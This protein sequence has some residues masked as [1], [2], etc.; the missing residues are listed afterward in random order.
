LTASAN[1]TRYNNTNGT[2]ASQNVS[3]GVYYLDTPPWVAGAISNAMTASDGAFNSSIEGLSGTVSTAGL[4]SGRHTVYVR[5]QDSA[6][7]WGPV[8]A[9]FLTIP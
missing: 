4:I 2:E 1:D 5:A 7:N 3:T 9:V 8:S 6:G